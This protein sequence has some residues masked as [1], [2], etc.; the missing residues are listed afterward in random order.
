MPLSTHGESS[1]IFF[2]RR[3]VYCNKLLV[4]AVVLC[5]EFAG[6]ISHVV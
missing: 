2:Q 1:Y 6:I 4:I 5:C 3:E